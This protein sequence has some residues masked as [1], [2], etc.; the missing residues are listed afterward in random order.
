MHVL[1]YKTCTNARQRKEKKT[2]VS[3]YRIN[4]RKSCYPI[5][6]AQNLEKKYSNGKV[7]AFRGPLLRTRIGEFSCAAY[8]GVSLLDSQSCTLTSD[9]VAHL[10]IVKIVKIVKKKES[11]ALAV[12]A[13]LHSMK[14]CLS[15]LPLPSMLFTLKLSPNKKAMSLHQNGPS[16]EEMSHFSY[17]CMRV[18]QTWYIYA[19]MYAEKAQVDFNQLVPSYCAPQFKEVAK[20]ICALHFFR[21]FIMAYSM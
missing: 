19:I 21:F 18:H 20:I 17:S 9:A 16:C 4:L 5:W 11:A 3:K 8:F 7:I 10:G 13:Y 6:A 12:R 14:A 2:T 15:H 1:C